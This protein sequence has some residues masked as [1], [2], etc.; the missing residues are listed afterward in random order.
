MNISTENQNKLKVEFA[1]LCVDNI[2]R[3]GIQDLLMYLDTT[4]FF[5]SPAST[6]YHGSYAGGLV[7]HSLDVYYSLIDELK[8]I[9]GEQWQKR[10][11]LETVTIVA[12]FHDLCKINNYIPSVKNVKNLET[13]RWETQPY[14]MYNTDK[15]RLGH[16]SGS[17]YE[18]TKYMK[19][20]EEEQLAIYWHMGAYD[21]S[22][23]ST[24]Q[25]MHNVYAKSVL[26]FALNRAD[27]FATYIVDNQDFTPIDY[28]QQS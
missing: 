13:G 10:Y 16:G 27:M 19:L 5:V 24:Q 4:D 12:L 1:K 28:E 15:L 7:Q 21:I 17:I 11:S 23:Y 26:A 20:T 9:Y 14:Y 6:K 2:K 18:I 8:F 3:D 25:D 22:P